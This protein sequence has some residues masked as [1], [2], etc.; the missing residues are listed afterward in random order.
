M[1]GCKIV[2]PGRVMCRKLLPIYE[3]SLIEYLQGENEITDAS[4]ENPGRIQ[5]L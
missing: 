2:S 4:S 3:K 5:I 1:H